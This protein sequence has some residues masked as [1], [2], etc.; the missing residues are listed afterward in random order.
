MNPSPIDKLSVR[1]PW[2]DE[3][4]R[5]K[6]F[7]AGS[8]KGAE[9]VHL[10]VLLA[11]APE[12]IVGAAAVKTILGA[13]GTRSA[14]ITLKVRPQQLEGEG[15]C[16]LMDAVMEKLETL[17]CAGVISTP[18]TVAP[19]LSLLG[20]YGFERTK[21]EELWRLEL[22]KVKQ[23]LDRVAARVR[24]P[25][26]WVVRAPKESDLPQLIELC[27]SYGFLE[28]SQI[29]FDDP[30]DMPGTH[31]ATSLCTVVENKGSIIAALLVKGGT[32]SNCHVDVRLVR[33]SEKE[34]SG[35]LNFH[36]LHNS[37]RNC[38][39]EGYSTNTLTV[40]ST[41]DGE[42]RNLARRSGGK[43]IQ[44]KDLFRLAKC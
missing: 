42:T 23:R 1:A 2:P 22:H 25:Q 33:D 37:T 18:M 41:R 44:S 27:E 5:M 34:M 30:G 8:L 29:K 16:L 3:M 36:M 13:D 9:S 24:L 39:A 6:Q 14:E 21:T 31:F 20:K 43:C 4:S 19:H 11:A 35:A 38:L 15:G 7:L 10:L 32:G 12:R 17:D 26:A 40:N 28:A